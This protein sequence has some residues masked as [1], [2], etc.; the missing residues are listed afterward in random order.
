[1]K[2]NL[3]LLCLIFISKLSFCQDI[4]TFKTG[5]EKTIKV[6]EVGQSEIKY[7][8][9]D[10]STVLYTVA[11]TDVFM[12]KYKD[13]SKDVFG[14]LE[15]PTE[16]NNNNNNNSHYNSC[17]NAEQDAKVDYKPSAGV[18]LG[19][20]FTPLCFGPLLGLIPTISFAET[21]PDVSNLAISKKNRSDDAY[22]NCYQKAARKQK[23]KTA[24]TWFASGAATWVIIV[25]AVVNS[26]HN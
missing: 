6:L 25:F 10:S 4:I 19:S 15:K 26:S 1:M 2:K 12:I 5:D 16:M 14:Q 7:K 11:K 21:T 13:G 8:K 3:L 20:F 9:D 18:A 23:A 17:A 22:V 24:W